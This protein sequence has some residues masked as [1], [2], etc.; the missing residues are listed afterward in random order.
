MAK[1]NSEFIFIT[2][3]VSPNSVYS[4]ISKDAFLR[5]LDIVINLESFDGINIKG[6][7]KDNEIYNCTLDEFIEELNDLNN[8][9]ICKV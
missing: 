5:R 7:D 4:V 1:F 9:Y 2:S 3:N 6:L 8:D